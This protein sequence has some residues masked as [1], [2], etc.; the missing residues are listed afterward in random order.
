MRSS[1]LAT[2]IE[3]PGGRD[4]EI[5]VTVVIPVVVDVQALGI[6]VADVDMIAIG[7]HAH[8]LLS[9]LS[10][11]FVHEDLRLNFIREYS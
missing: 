9:S 10:P 7:V 8:C 3:I 5:A 6:E 1:S 2:L 4:T 11:P